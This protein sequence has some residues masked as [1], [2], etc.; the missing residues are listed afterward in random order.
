MC[1]LT[2]AL[3]KA[4]WFKRVLFL[5]DRTALVNQTVNVFK[6][7]LPSVPVVNLLRRSRIRRRARHV[8]GVAAGSGR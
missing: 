2:V 8:A 1:P 6:Q 4:N 7:Q 5:A 3:M